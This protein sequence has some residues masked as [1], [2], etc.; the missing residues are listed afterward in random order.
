[1]KEVKSPKKPLLY[2][3]GITLLVILLFNLL[4]APLIARN[5]VTETDYGTFMQMIEDKDIGKVQVESDQIIFTG[6]SGGTVYTTGA[7]DDPTLTQRL[8]DAGAT[9]TKEVQQTTSPLLSFF[10]TIVLPLLIFL[11]IGQYMSKKLME[12]AGGKNSLMFGAGRSSAK[13]YVQSSQGI[14]FSDVAGEDEA[15]ENLQEIVD[16]LH[17]P[18]KYTEA[19]AS[20]PKGILLVGPP[21][22]GKTM[23]AKAVAGESNVPF[24]SISGSEFVEMFVGMGASKVRDLFKQAKEK[25]PCIVF[26]D[27]IDAI[28]QKRNSGNLGGNDEREQTLNQLLTEMD[29]FEGNTGVIILAATN[30]PESLDHRLCQHRFA[31]ARRANQQCALWQL[32]TDGSVLVRVVQ[33]VHDFGQGFLGLILTGDI[34][35]GLA[36][37]GLGVNLG[38]GFAEAHHV[39][40]HV[41]HHLFLQPLTDRDNEHNRHNVGDEHAQQGRGLRGN[42]GSELDTGIE[43]TACQLVIREDAGLVERV[44]ALVVLGLEGDL[45]VLLVVSDG[46]D[47]TLVHHGD[48]LVVADLGHLPLQQAWKQQP[49]EHHKHEQHD[50]IIEDQ[51]FSGIF[52]PF[53]VV[54]H[55]RFVLS[56][57]S[58]RFR[59][60]FCIT[61]H[62]VCI[63]CSEMPCCSVSAKVSQ[64]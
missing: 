10:L 12:Q 53:G 19:G 27:E 3:Y 29:G 62:R 31:S 54:I 56:S 4:V 28:G 22:T 39:A 50:R 59:C 35:K 58:L 43:Q 7:M 23:L 33:E 63:S 17:N 44:L 16:Y 46:L 8:Y 48:E 1:M 49:V 64:R 55:V 37:L 51:R 13:V 11:G 32:C 34:G 40:A 9:F 52:R 2:Y 36:G 30:R 25:A 61:L 20:M 14:R 60:I 5:Q 57:K 24:F 45:L 15:K 18:Q 21:G 42:L 6:K 26:I 41:L 38:V 47:L